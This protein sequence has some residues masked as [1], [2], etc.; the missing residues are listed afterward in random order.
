MSNIYLVAVKQQLA[1]HGVEGTYVRISAGVYDIAEGSATSTSTEST[2]QVYKQH[3]KASQYNMPHLVGKNAALFMIAGDA[4]GFLPKIKDQ[5]RVGTETY[6]VDSYQE[7][8]ANG[9]IC[10]LKIIALQG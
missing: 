9:E 3:I 5:I 1:Q 7:H 6:T 2:I 8:K 10:M 4:L